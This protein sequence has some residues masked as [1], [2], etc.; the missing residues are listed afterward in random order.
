MTP[1]PECP[2]CR[3]ILVEGHA[4]CPGCGLEVSEESAGCPKCGENIA[5]DADVCPACGHL[6]IEATCQNHPDQAAPG[7]CA[8][9]AVTL[10][11]ECE[12]GD[13]YHQ[14]AEHADVS[15]IE[16]WAEILSLSDEVEAALIAENLRA[17]GIDARVLSQKDHSA[18]PVD[19]GDLARIRLLAPTYA[20]QEAQRVLATHQDSVGEVS[21]G[22]PNCG[23]PYDEGSR[24]CQACGEALV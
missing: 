17:E 23:D 21:F 13:R 5:A 22:C 6:L 10:C 18:F 19:L 12:A 16:G 3:T 1:I 8:L 4:T 20:Y 14:C 15:I 9:C 24:Q 7:Q 2:E 11:G